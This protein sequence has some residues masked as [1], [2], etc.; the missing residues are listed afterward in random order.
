MKKEDKYKSIKEAQKRLV[1]SKRDLLHGVDHAS[2]VVENAF[3]IIRSEKLDVDS[4]VVELVCWWHDIEFKEPKKNRNRPCVYTA[5][6]LAKKFGSKE[7]IIIDSISN[8]EFGNMPK[9]MEGKVL[10]D[11]DKIEYVNLN[12]L[13]KVYDYFD[14]GLLTKDYVLSVINQVLKVFYPE[15]AKNLNFDYSK[16]IFNKKRPKAE[17]LLY[18]IRS[19]V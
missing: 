5:K 14:M 1:E 9:S 18:E 4:D 7:S 16:K 13:Q 6:Y 3:N 8:H 15:V 17:K 11:A 10:Y 2:M 19:Y 12:R